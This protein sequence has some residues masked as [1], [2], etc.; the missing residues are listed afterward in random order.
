MKTEKKTEYIGSI[1][2]YMQSFYL[3]KL[4]AEFLAEAC[5]AE[6]NVI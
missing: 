6:C 4:N 1:M 5:Q 2:N 3:K